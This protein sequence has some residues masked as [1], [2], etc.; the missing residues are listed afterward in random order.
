[1]L[2]PRTKYTQWRLNDSTARGQATRNGSQLYALDAATGAARW[3][4][5]PACRP[6]L[7]CGF[8]KDGRRATGSP[9]YGAGFY[10]SPVY[11]RGVVYIGSEWGHIHALNASDG[12]TVWEYAPLFVSKAGAP[13]I[14]GRCKSSVYNTVAIDPVT[15]RLFF[16]SVDCHVY[17]VDLRSGRQLWNISTASQIIDTASPALGGGM[18]FVGTDRPN[19]TDT[20]HHCLYA[21]GAKT[22]EK[23]WTWC[24]PLGIQSSPAATEASVFVAA[25]ADGPTAALFALDAKTGAVQWRFKPPS[26]TRGLDAAV[27]LSPDNRTIVVGGG[28]CEFSRSCKRSMFC[29]SRSMMPPRCC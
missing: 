26:M 28:G 10:S 20:S 2:I 22:G 27:G 5:R 23:A 8:A 6:A 1:V 13:W 4:F 21:I 9:L 18:V 17:S 24:V 11:H 29:C 12:R 25:P 15:R 7:G 14:E 3:S 16:G 19:G